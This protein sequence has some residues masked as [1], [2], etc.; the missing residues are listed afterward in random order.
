MMRLFLLLALTTVL[1]AQVRTANIH[2]GNG[3][4]KCTLELVVDGA[5]EVEIRG[6]NA[7][8]RTREGRRATW[9]R[10]DCNRPMP[11]NPV[12][13]QVRGIDGRGKQQLLRAPG[14][15]GPAVVLIEDE[16][17]G[18]EGYTFDITWD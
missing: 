3:G 12:N 8:I 17:G 16:K 4:G 18:R 10:F 15:D 13:F 5:A 9:T 1:P 6:R 14:P 2:G 7:R 11:R